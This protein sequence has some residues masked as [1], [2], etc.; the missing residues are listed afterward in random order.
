[1]GAHIMARRRIGDG[2]PPHLLGGLLKAVLDQVEHEDAMAAC[3]TLTAAELASHELRKIAEVRTA[4]I[5]LVHAGMLRIG[6]APLGR[7]QPGGRYAQAFMPAPASEER[8]PAR[9]PRLRPVGL[10]ITDDER[11]A[12][13]L[14]RLL[15]EE[16]VLPV[17]VLTVE[18]ALVLLRHVGF[19]MAIAVDT[20]ARLP[21]LQTAARQAGCGPVVTLRGA[22]GDESTRL[23]RPAGTAAEGVVY[24]LAL[25]QAV[26]TMVH[27]NPPAFLPYV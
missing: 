27:G 24:P 11:R 10:L 23:Q 9:R 26:A 19:E 20:D 21:L 2:S 25:R 6:R 15:R 1:M 8:G 14:G 7:T 22:D 4:A 16:G 17:A 5:E 3:R 13:D 12:P 18:D